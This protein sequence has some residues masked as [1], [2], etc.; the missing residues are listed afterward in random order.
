MIQQFHFLVYTPKNW[1][2][3]PN[4][5]LYFQIHNSIIQNCQKVEATQM[6]FNGQMV[7]KM[8]YM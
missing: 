2:Q 7:N 3:G 8:W 4:R 6:S 1:K 5:Y